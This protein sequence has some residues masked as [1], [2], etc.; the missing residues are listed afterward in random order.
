MESF[1]KLIKKKDL[2]KKEIDSYLLASFITE[3]IQKV[4]LDELLMII[5]I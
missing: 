3:F 4:T 2:L 5:L 1:I